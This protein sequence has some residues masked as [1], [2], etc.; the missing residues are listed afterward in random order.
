MFSVSPEL[1]VKYDLIDDTRYRYY[2]ESETPLQEPQ[3]ELKTPRN[4]TS[5]EFDFEVSNIIYPENLYILYISKFYKSLKP[6]LCQNLQFLTYI[7]FDVSEIPDKC[8]ENCISLKSVRATNKLYKIGNS[9]FKNCGE[10]LEIENVNSLYKIGFSAFENCRQLTTFIPAKIIEHDAYRNSGLIE[11]NINYKTEF[12]IE[13][14]GESIF[15]DCI[16]LESVSFYDINLPNSCFRGCINL[17]KFNTNISYIEK[18]T[19]VN[20]GF[21]VLHIPESITTIGEHALSN[22]SPLRKIIVN[23]IC[24]KIHYNQIINNDLDIIILN[25]KSNFL[26]FLINNQ[27][28]IA[29]FVNSDRNICIYHNGSNAMSDLK[30]TIKS[31]H[32]NDELLPLLEDGHA[33]I[34]VI[35]YILLIQQYYILEEEDNVRRMVSQINLKNSELNVEDLDILNNNLKDKLIRLKELRDI[36]DLYK[37]R[38]N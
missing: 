22:I 25:P 36:Y 6:N 24:L 12:K 2:R 32:L 35:F 23:N 27:H 7:S 4:K 31:L 21:N 10:L 14:I 13:Q 5:T 29:S 18:Y 33:I 38:L 28:F 17:T 20:T 30:D 19:F 1:F 15:K 9:A 37:S 16:N 34:Y 11:V 26:K 8:F 3:N